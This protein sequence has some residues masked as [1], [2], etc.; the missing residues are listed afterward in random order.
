MLEA[1]EGARRPSPAAEITSAPARLKP[2]LAR[3]RAESRVTQLSPL[4]IDLHDATLDA[5]LDAIAV[6][7][8]TGSCVMHLHT[9]GPDGVG[10]DGDRPVRVRWHGLRELGVVGGAPWGRSASV[11]EAR[12]GEDGAD[13]IQMQ[14]GDVIRVRAAGRAVEADVESVERRY[15]G[16]AADALA[17]AGVIVRAD[18]E[19]AAV[20][21]ADEIRVRRRLGDV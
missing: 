13:E 11:L 8:P 19:R 2:A 18:G 14:S 9:V 16:L 5:M 21:V 12:W 20:A 15:G 10:L 4:P 6:E 7:W 1:D 17:D 3:T